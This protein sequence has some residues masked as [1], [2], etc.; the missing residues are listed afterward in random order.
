M[1]NWCECDLRVYGSKEEM[2]RFKEY[3]ALEGRRGLSKP[4]VYIR[5]DINEK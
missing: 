3:A 4:A 1:P 2:S 5:R